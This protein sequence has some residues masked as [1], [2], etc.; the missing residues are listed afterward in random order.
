VRKVLALLQRFLTT[1]HCFTETAFLVDVPRYEFLYQFVSLSALLS[2][3][4]SELRLQSGA[5]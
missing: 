1:F 5:K 3:G 4:L 2:C